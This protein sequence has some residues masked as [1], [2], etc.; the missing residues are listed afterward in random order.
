MIEFSETAH[1]IV[2]ASSALERGELRSKGE[3]K[4]TIH[5]NGREQNVEMILR[6]VMSANQ[7]SIYGA[8]ADFCTVVS[9]DTMASGKLEAHEAQD[10]LETMEIATQPGWI[11]TTFV[12]MKIVTV[13]KFRSDLCFKTE[14]PHGF[15][16]VNGVEKY[17]N[18]TTETMEDEEHGALEKPYCKSKTSNEININ[19]DTR[20]RSSTRKKVGGRQSRKL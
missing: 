7:L 14:P 18:E 11:L 5:F 19:A 13:L 12:I 10:P 15:E 3:G 6:T 9:K 8:V 17:V 20:V 1:P 16:K 4:K 2:L